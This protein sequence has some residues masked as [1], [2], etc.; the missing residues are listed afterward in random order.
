MMNGIVKKISLLGIALITAWSCQAVDYNQHFG[1][2]A[3]AY[4]VG[5]GSGEAPSSADMKGVGVRPGD[6]VINTDDDALFIMSTTNV[7]TKIEAD[8]T[9]TIVSMDISDRMD[10]GG[11]GYAGEHAPLA[12]TD[13]THTM[14]GFGQFNEVSTVVS[15]GKVMAAKY[16]RLLISESQTN[17]STFIGTE[18]QLRLRGANIGEGVHAGLWAYA[19]Q[20]GVST[21]SDAGTFDAITATVESE[22]TYVVGA[23]EQISGITLDSSIN[24]GATIDGSANFSAVYIKSNGKDWFNGIYITGCD[25]A[26]LFD[27]G[28]T[29]DQSAADTLTFTED[30]VDVVGDFT[31]STIKADNG[32]TSNFT[33]L[34]ATATTGKMWFSG[35]VL[36]NVTL[37][38]E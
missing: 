8:G 32:I 24:A 12:D 28:A 16:S 4:R 35:G 14:A 18:S 2:P 13:E 27:G 3:R 6:I 30:K 17:S 36:T 31:A 15:A 23:T 7:Y 21:Q 5:L 29:I 1:R 38:G 33:F 25:N 10:I 37:S 26:I 9:A 20:S 11:W 19:E 34:S 22:A